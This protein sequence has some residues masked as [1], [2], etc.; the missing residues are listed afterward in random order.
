MGEVERGKE[1]GRE[2]ERGTHMGQRHT[3]TC[4]YTRTCNE[5]TTIDAPPH[6]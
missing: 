2:R 1:G 5:S 4:T 3:C 6:C